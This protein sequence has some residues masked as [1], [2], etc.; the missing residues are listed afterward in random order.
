MGK[1]ISV[2]PGVSEA[3]KQL[4][5]IL[6]NEEY[7]GFEEDAHKYVEKLKKAIYNDLPNL[8]HYETPLEI[9]KYG[10]YYVKLKG[11]K[12]TMWYVFFEKS[13]NRYL[14]QFITNN[15]SPQSA[16]LNRL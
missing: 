10:R 8:T 15:Y 2:S 5:W 7:F 1:I 6:Y 9:K 3:L 13:G 14:I 11:N 16:Y 4:V 12:R